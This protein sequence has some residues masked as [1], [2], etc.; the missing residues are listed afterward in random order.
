MSREYART[1]RVAQLLKEEISRLLQREVKDARIGMVTVTDVRVTNDLKYADVFVY[2]S[3]D[4]DRRAQAIE[5]LKS[6]AG[7]MRSRL[8]R[9][10]RIRR[11]PELRF[12]MD[13][14]Q[15]HAARIHQLL[16]EVGPIEE[17]D[18]GEDEDER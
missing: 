13:R 9:D 2:L 4:E 18:E 14:T 5:G 8:G 10:L 6:A 3:G 16:S 12:V 7:F 17:C 11:T 1:Q 15:D